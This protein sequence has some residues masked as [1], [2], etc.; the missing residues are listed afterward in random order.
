[1][2]HI[3]DRLIKELDICLRTLFP[4]DCRQSKRPNPADNEIN[5]SLGEQERCHAAGLMR[6]NHSGEVCAQALYQGQALTARQPHIQA[7]LR[8]AALEEEEHLAWCEARLRALDSSPSLLN[9]VWYGASFLLGGF[10]GLLGDKISLG[11]VAE[12]ERQVE[13]HLASHL[14][15]LPLKDVQ[16]RAVVAQMQIDEQRHAHEAISA[17][18]LIFPRFIQRLMR[19][20]AKGMTRTSYYV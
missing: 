19:W 10:A 12:V 18:G 13:A 4:P 14:A 17:G 9:P 11:F 8:E 5:E 2:S 6:V 15:S 3:E 1:M 20:I 16:S 7:Q